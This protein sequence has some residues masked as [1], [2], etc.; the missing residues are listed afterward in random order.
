V[1]SHEYFPVSDLS[2]VNWGHF[3]AFAWGGF[4]VVGLGLGFDSGERL[5]V[6]GGLIRLGLCGGIVGDQVRGVCGWEAGDGAE[7][8]REDRHAKGTTLVYNIVRSMIFT[9]CRSLY[10]P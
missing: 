6:S 1:V 4:A 9:L 2:V 8:E 5:S 7:L 3:P 10:S